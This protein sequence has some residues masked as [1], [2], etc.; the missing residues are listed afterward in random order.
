M[1][2]SASSSD[3]AAYSRADRILHR[4]ALGWT[5]AI[6]TSFDLEWA[7]F[8]RRAGAIP[9][10]RPIFVCGLARAGSSLAARTIAAAPG[11]ASP[12]YRDMPF[13]LAPNCWARLAGR[14]RL[15]AAPRGHGDGLG[16]DLDTPEAIE[17]VFWRCFEGDRYLRPEGLAPVPPELETLERLR[18]YMALVLLAGR[19]RRYVSKNNNNILRV[20]S[21]A[22]AFPDALFVHPF[23]HPAAQAASLERQ[24]VRAA[25][26]Q[27]ADPFR[28]RYAE[29][30]GHHE[31]GLG[32]RPFLLPGGNG[33]WVAAW[34][35]V[36]RHLLEQPEGVRG[37]QFFLDYDALCRTPGAVL[38]A[39]GRFLGTE[40]LDGMDVHAPSADAAAIPWKV[41]HIYRQLRE[42][43]EG[44]ST[45]VTGE[46]GP[47]RE[48]GGR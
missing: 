28:L 36:Y 3:D 42:R 43:A 5:G 17:E 33:D 23:R 39:L 34:G 9:V 6:E 26:R 8:G 38:G 47:A 31:F 13:P 27:R 10:E 37:R 20:A 24:H 21:L 15:E 44:R 11:L 46:E 14:R 29:W 30:L 35:A 16:H 4:L 41:Q 32:R 7:A 2:P 12:R 48:A 45:V 25:G 18:R 19:G 1:P 22:E 40:P